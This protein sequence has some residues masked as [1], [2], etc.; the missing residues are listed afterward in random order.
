MKVALCMSGH[1]RYFNK[2]SQ[3][4]V[5]AFKKYN[6]DLF[7]HSWENAGYQK[8]NSGYKH[9]T[10]KCADLSFISVLNENGIV[11]RSM[12]FENEA[13]GMKFINAEKYKQQVSVPNEN[14]LSMYRK[15][16]LC[17]NL[18]SEYEK[19]IG[20][21]YDIVI[22]CR[23]DLMFNSDI[24][25]QELEDCLKSNIVYVPCKGLQHPE[26]RRQIND[27]FA[28]GNSFSMDYYSNLYN[29]IDAY[30]NENVPVPPLVNDYCG[31]HA[32]TLL[33]FHMNKNP[34]IVLKETKTKYILPHKHNNIID[35]F[36]NE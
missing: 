23:P 2:L 11:P 1:V 8:R 12:I 29:Q 14:I 4:F 7:F 19:Q 18:K 25:D 9:E 5:A 3:N 6:P 17:N 24:P 30:Y 20:F 34:N 22:K 36:Q 31:I 16:M 27:H 35:R 32:E 13:I 26:Y 28:F 10:S 21:K 33:N 15:I